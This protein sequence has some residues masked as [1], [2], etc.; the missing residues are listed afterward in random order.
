[1]ESVP[2][3]HNQTAPFSTAEIGKRNTG[4]NN[5]S[6]AI[7]I[8]EVPNVYVPRHAGE[9][10]KVLGFADEMIMTGY[11]LRQENFR[12]RGLFINYQ[13]VARGVAN[14]LVAISNDKTRETYLRVLDR[15]SKKPLKDIQGVFA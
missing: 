7:L 13:Y 1:M 3:T 11:R 2:N 10:C 14:L 6:R 5:T 8:L 15:L 12:R 9:V 4:Y